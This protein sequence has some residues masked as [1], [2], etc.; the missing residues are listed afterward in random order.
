MSKIPSLSDKI[1]TAHLELIMILAALRIIDMDSAVD[2]RRMFRNK[3][4]DLRGKR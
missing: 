2:A 3:E 4:R 1:S